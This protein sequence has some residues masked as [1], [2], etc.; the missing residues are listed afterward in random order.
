MTSSITL[1]I[2][3]GLL[4]ASSLL[5]AGCHQADVKPDT[6]AASKTAVKQEAKQE[7]NAAAPALN[8]EDFYEA[9][10]E[11]RIYLFDDFATYASFLDVGETAFR[12]TYIGAGPKGETLVI[13]LTKHDKKKTSGIA[14]EDMYNGKLE[15]AADFYG[16]MLYEDRLYVFNNW[17]D[18]QDMRATGEAPYRYTDIAAGPKGITV[19]Y[20]LNKHNKKVRPD[21][22][23]ENFKAMHKL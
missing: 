10:A 17:K 12:R 18:M 9:H 20:V 15:P 13:G 3:A 16:E 19:V 21:A 14:S 8:N 1:R 22:L 5:L 4:L 7:A 11:G 2:G 23:I 6:A